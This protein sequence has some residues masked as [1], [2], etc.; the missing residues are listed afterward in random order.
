VRSFWA[1][2]T[3][4]SPISRLNSLLTYRRSSLLA[5]PLSSRR[6]FAVHQRHQQQVQADHLQ[7]QAR[8][9]ILSLN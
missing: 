2:W 8:L 7:G 9:L 5:F 6:L 1:P 3:P 4:A